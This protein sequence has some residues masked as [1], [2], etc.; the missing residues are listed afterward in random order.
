MPEQPESLDEALAKIVDFRDAR[1]WAQYHTP[2]QLSR[3]LSI[4]ASEL[5]EE[6]QWKG[7]EEA[8]DFVTTEEG[9]EAA[10]EEIGDVLIYA[11]LFCKRVGINPLEAIGAKLEKNREKFP[12]EDVKGQATLDDRQAP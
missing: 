7:P 8:Q 2:E 10:K 4:E 11:L 12:V 6:F 9:R 1:D 3:A 5:E